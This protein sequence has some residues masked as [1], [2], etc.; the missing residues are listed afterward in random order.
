MIFFRASIDSTV[1]RGNIWQIQAE[2]AK[3]SQKSFTGLRPSS[4]SFRKFHSR[5]FDKVAMRAYFHF[6]A[7]E[8]AN[9]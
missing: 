6:F 5:K 2:T 7:A 3:Y 8:H 4:L 1:S 9:S